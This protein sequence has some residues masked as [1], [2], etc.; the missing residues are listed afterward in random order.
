M[1][2]DDDLSNSNLYMYVCNSS[3]YPRGKSCKYIIN[4][5]RICSCFYLLATCNPYCYV[6]RSNL[7][8]YLNSGFYSARTSAWYTEEKGNNGLEKLWQY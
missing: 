3:L 2:L 6:S 8:P 5:H 4:S 1:K 7:L